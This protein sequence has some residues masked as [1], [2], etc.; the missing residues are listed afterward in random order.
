MALRLLVCKPRTAGLV[1]G[2]EWALNRKLSCQASTIKR[3]YVSQGASSVPGKFR[4]E[5][6]TFGELEVPADRYY[7]AQTARSKINFSIGDATTERMP[8][9]HFNSHSAVGVLVLL[10]PNAQIRVI[11]AFGYLKRACAAV[12]KE[13]YGLDPK[14]AD[15]IILAATEVHEGKLDDHFPLVVWQ[16]GSGTQSNM[17]VNEVI[18]NR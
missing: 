13:F 15:A 6:D 10:S 1:S 5:Y 16:T 14:L 11:H 18:S 2:A 3:T 9:R 12:N 7:G 17:N 8:V 4:K